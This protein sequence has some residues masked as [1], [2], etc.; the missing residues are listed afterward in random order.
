MVV[1]YRVSALTWLVGRLL[2]DVP[3]Y[4]M[5][6]L[7]AGRQ[8][9]RELFQ[10]DFTGLKVAREVEKLL[11]KREIREKM[12]AELGEVKSALGHPGAVERAAESIL[13]MLNSQHTRPRPR[14]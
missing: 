5:V 14:L 12:I 13:V 3:F 10:S 7:I 11:D 6:N 2:V 4:S 8:V 9:V 1:V